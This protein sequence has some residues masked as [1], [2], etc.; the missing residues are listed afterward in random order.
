MH[1]IPT[2]YSGDARIVESGKR[3]MPVPD[4]LQ[5]KVGALVMMRKN[6]VSDDH[7]Y[8][9]G[10][11]GHICSITEDVLFITLLTGDTIEVEKQK[12]TSLDGDGNEVMAAWNFP[13]TLA[14]ATTI[15]KAQGASLDRMIVDLTA[16]WEPG[17]AYVAL[18]RVRSAQGL[19]IQQWTASSIRAEPLVTALYDSLAQEMKTYTP[20]PLYAP[21]IEEAPSQEKKS[22]S[23]GTKQRRA[24]MIRRL[25]DEGASL[26]SMIAQCGVKPDRV[27]LYM[28]DFLEQGIALS[29]G[30]LI[31]DLPD[32]S[33]IR[34]A[35]EEHG[36]ARLRPVFDALG[37]KI[38]YT[39]LRLVRCVMTAE[40]GA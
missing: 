40:S 3:N 39:T 1:E 12:F 7:L 16:L 22:T 9:N 23:A 35:F 24:A 25:I 21:T 38:D 31:A 26:E 15:H 10:S 36:T 11:L 2:Q 5:L 8:V 20:R 29:I 6:D 19:H 4:V 18:S 30:Y 13:V 14:W 27:L 37:E 34:A 28:E 17:Q 33:L 32:T